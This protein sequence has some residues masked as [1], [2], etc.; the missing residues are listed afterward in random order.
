[1]ENV[2]AIGV[3]EDEEEGVLELEGLEELVGDEE[4]VV[5]LLKT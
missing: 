5:K 1:L 4:P 2:E 3:L